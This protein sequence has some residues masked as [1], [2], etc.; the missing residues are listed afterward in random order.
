M[1]A[2]GTAL[3]AWSLLTA[4]CG[5]PDAE[6]DGDLRPGAERIVLIV[7]DML[8][9]DHVGVYGAPRP[10]PH[11]DALAARGQALQRSVSS[12]SSTT[13]S[14]GAIFSGRTPS[15]ETGD[16]RRPLRWN[17]R[18]WCGLARFAEPGDE[19]CLPRNL[20]TLAERLRDAGFETLGVT[21]N[22]LLYEPAGFARGFD[23][24]EEAGARTDEPPG[25]FEDEPRPYR[26]RFGGT[27]APSVNEAVRSLLDA[28]A[29]DRF[30]L[31][32]HYMDVHDFAAVEISYAEAVQRADSGVGE[33]V[34]L[35]EARGLLDGTSIFLT[36]DHGERLDEA[37]PFAVGPNHLGNPSFQ[38]LLDVPLVIAPPLLADRDRPLRGE[39]LMGVLLRAAGVELARESAV[40]PDELFVS[41]WLWQTYRRGGWKVMLARRGGR[42]LLYDLAAD[43]GEEVDL[44]AERPVVLEALRG[45]VGELTRALAATAS[46]ERTLTA[47]DRA[48]LDALGYVDTIEDGV[49][50]TRPSLLP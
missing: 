24:W 36:S 5:R 41:E 28:R 26:G 47:E 9:R 14:M 11:I 18:N 45:R 22:I 38:Y 3:L 10:T 23:R 16:P 40:E 17:G 31:Y 37:H 39:D 29:N 33:L 6:V 48:R 1:R 19:T 15:I 44:S 46:D 43:P 42:E 32:V 12:F 30:F 8:R 4:A 7:V 34:A 50:Q 27:L 21:S 49:T 13:M 35:L 25:E 2:I 20:P